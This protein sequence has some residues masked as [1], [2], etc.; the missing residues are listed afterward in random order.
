MTVLLVGILM[1]AHSLYLSWIPH[2]DNRW[3]RLAYHCGTDFLA[4]NIF[5]VDPR[6][7]GGEVHRVTTPP[8]MRC[9]LVV[10]I[11]RR[12]EESDLVEDGQVAESGYAS[13]D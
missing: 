9:S 1:S 3:V 5:D 10:D 11:I 4:I 12:T 8:G 13:L 7:T 6:A 2:P